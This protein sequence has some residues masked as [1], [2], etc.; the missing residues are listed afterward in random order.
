[1][2][3]YILLLFVLFSPPAMSMSVED[4]IEV[5]DCESS[6]RHNAVGDGGK[7]VGI[8]QFQKATFNWMKKAAGKPNWSWK[9]PIHQL[10]LMVWAVD[11]GYGDQW[12]CYRHLQKKKV[13]VM[14]KEPPA[15]F[16]L[17]ESIRY[18]PERYSVVKE[19][20]RWN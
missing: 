15:T 3:K 12:T 11:H 1:M 16:Y 9:N 6:G 4:A 13:Y 17:E 19:T 10:R 7:S 20:R 2:I 18:R 5:I 8:V 14:L